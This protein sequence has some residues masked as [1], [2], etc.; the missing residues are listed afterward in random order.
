MPRVPYCCRWLHSP[1]MKVCQLMSVGVQSSRSCCAQH[2]VDRRVRQRVPKL[3][4]SVSYSTRVLLFGESIQELSSNTGT[5]LTE[6]ILRM[7]LKS[8]WPNIAP[9][10]TQVHA[11]RH[12]RVGLLHSGQQRNPAK[13]AHRLQSQPHHHLSRFLPLCTLPVLPQLVLHPP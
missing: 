10:F 1:F 9:S 3:H 8:L 6:H 11:R 7:I 13:P 2:T 5:S 4:L 12:S